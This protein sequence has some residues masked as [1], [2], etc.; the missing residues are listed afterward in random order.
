MTPPPQRRG[1]E[2]ASRSGVHY[3]KAND[4]TKERTAIGEAKSLR[5]PEH[6]IIGSRGSLMFWRTDVFQA[7]APK[8]GP[9]DKSLGREADPAGGKIYD[10]GSAW[11]GAQQEKKRKSTRQEIL[12]RQSRLAFRLANSGINLTHLFVHP[13]QPIF[14]V[15]AHV[16]YLRVMPLLRR[17]T[18]LL[19][20]RQSQSGGPEEQT[21]R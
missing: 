1:G 21:L 2:L 8:S 17:F 18:H 5:G 14:V 16:Q 12:K 6:S 4:K 7:E 10:N 15:Y 9:I 3:W 19:V 13:D 20:N 11:A